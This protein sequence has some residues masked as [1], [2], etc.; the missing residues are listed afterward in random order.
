MLWLKI[1]VG[2]CIIG[3]IIGLFYSNGKNPLSNAAN[4]A[5]TGGCMAAGCILRIAIAALI[6]L[7]ILWIFGILF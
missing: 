4:G 5:V 7:G 1:I 6:I 2:C 3:A